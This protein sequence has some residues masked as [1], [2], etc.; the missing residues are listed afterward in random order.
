MKQ[1][2]FDEV[3]AAYAQVKQ[4]AEILN[5]DYE[6]TC[7]DIDAAEAE[8]KELPLAPVPLEDMKEA[9]LE[10]I[11]ASGTRYA[12]IIR[13]HISKFA[14][15]KTSFESVPHGSGKLQYQ[16]IGKPLSF[17]I[18]DG[19]ISGE[20]AS[21]RGAQLLNPLASFFDDRVI[22]LF[23]GPLVREGLRKIME[24]M[25]P[26]EF[27]YDR[28]QPDK[29]GSTRRERR[30]A[31]AALQERLGKLHSRKEDLAGKLA[32]LGFPVP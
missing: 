24:Q 22:Y 5:A 18:L 1:N 26:E 9:I 25:G 21:L 7:R 10:F 11:D 14:N 19:S 15:G 4:T 29:I 13:G 28:I 32:A 16:D 31:I 2:T 8:L 30:A 3:A 20:D 12:E 23:C 6:Q 27:G 17:E